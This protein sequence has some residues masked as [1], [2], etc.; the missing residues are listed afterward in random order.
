MSTP[1]VEPGLSRP[2]R[3]VLTTRRCGPY[4]KWC[5]WSALGKQLSLTLDIVIACSF[6]AAAMGVGLLG[7]NETVRVGLDVTS[8]RQ[9]LL[10]PDKTTTPRNVFESGHCETM[11]CVCAFCGGGFESGLLLS[12]IAHSDS[13]PTSQS[14]ICRLAAFVPLPKIPPPGL[15]PGSLG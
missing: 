2:Q 3:D 4:R 15:E 8:H 7:S 13:L 10:P 5:A 1:G 12:L 9:P 11:Q 6:Q 14:S